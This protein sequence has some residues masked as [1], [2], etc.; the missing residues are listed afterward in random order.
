MATGV[1]TFK[2]GSPVKDVNSIS[3]DIDFLISQLNAANVTENVLAAAADDELL[4]YDAT[5]NYWINRT[6][7]EAG[8]LYPVAITAAASGDYIRHNGTN[9]VDVTIS[10]IITDL[11][12]DDIVGGSG[13]DVTNGADT[14]IGG[15]ATLALGALSGPWDAGAQQ[16]RAL[17]FY[18]DGAVSRFDSDIS[19]TTNS[20]LFG[21]FGSE[22][23]EVKRW[24]ANQWGS[25]D[26]LGIGA[27]PVSKAEVYTSGDNSA[28]TVLDDVGGLNI[29]RAQDTAN[30]FALLR[31]R[32][33][34]AASGL[35]G[36]DGTYIKSI[37]IGNNETDLAFGS[38][39]TVGGIIESM[40]LKQ[41]GQ[42][43]FPVTGSGAGIVI[44]GDFKIYRSAPN[45]GY[46]PDSFTSAL[47]IQAEHFYSTD[48]VVVDSDL[49]VGGNIAVQNAVSPQISLV[50]TTN[51]VTTRLLSIDTYGIVG[52]YSN[53]PLLLVSNSTSRFSISAAGHLLAFADNSYDIGAS[54]ANRPKDLY[55][56]GVATIGGDFNHDGTN[57]GLY[58]A[59][60][61]AQAAHITDPTDLAESIVA[62][63]AILVALENIGIT[64]AV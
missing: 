45:V 24:A 17:N 1:T 8:L 38:Y 42:V 34:G 37:T 33:W 52:T 31:F 58:A 22:D 36:T 49:S 21:T 11:A 43:Q 53:H 28:S 4:S 23:V 32:N 55:L 13:I 18:A 44:G 14:I 51:T 20:L 9:F 46:T 7:A 2:R 54:G 56:A 5:N 15:N 48:D 3:R 35:S 6:A 10:Q 27:A 60:P 41:A 29:T 16:I 39:K 12:L 40:R 30:V 61:T 26:A 59:T 62:I 19:L 63:N 50:D 57:V 47:T 25:V 64:A